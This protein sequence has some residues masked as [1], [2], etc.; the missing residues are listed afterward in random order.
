MTIQK[1]EKPK[2]TSVRSERYS[3]LE[4]I[5]TLYGGVTWILAIAA[6]VGFFWGIFGDDA[7]RPLG[8]HLSL[9]S[10]V[11][12]L[13]WCLSFQAISEGITVVIDIEENT[14]RTADLLEKN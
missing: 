4:L 13:V 6:I 11:V 1:T 5:S 2:G 7:P 12:G 10:A 9:L 14:R 3:T 8:I